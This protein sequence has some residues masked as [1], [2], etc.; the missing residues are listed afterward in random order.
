MSYIVGFLTIWVIC[1]LIKPQII[2]STEDASFSKRVF[3]RSI[4]STLCFGVGIIGGEGFGL[5]GP[6]LGALIFYNGPK[7]YSYTAIIP[8]VF[9]LLVFFLWHSFDYKAQKKPS[10]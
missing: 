2:V 9:W 6:I 7:F 8:F 10:Q 3:S 1:F 5:P 4:I